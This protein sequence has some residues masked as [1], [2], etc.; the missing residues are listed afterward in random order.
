MS[1]P[2]IGASLALVVSLVAAVPTLQSQSA[3]AGPVEEAG[4]Q[5]VYVISFDENQVTG[6]E[7]QR[8]VERSGGSL[9]DTLEPVGLALVTA[10]GEGFI[11]EVQGIDGVY[12]T[13]R[14]HAVGAAEPGLPHRFA[15][16]EVPPHERALAAIRAVSPDE[17]GGARDD[18]TVGAEPL[19][20]RQWGM[21]MIGATVRDAHR[22]AT[23]QGVDV[24][25]IDTGIDGSHPDLAPNFDANRSRN[26]VRDDA[27][28]SDADANG[29]G[30]HVAGVVAAAD[31]GLGIAGVAP[32]ATLVNLRAGN[33]AGYFFV[34][35]VVSA[36][37]AAG[38]M[39]LDVVN[40]SFFTDPWLY[41]CESADDYLEGSAS[42]EEI[43]EQALVRQEVLEAV[44]YARERGVTLVAAI[45][46][47]H[48]D[49]AAPRRVDEGSPDWPPGAAHR[50][51]VTRNCL[52][53]P[54][55]APGVLSVSSVG[56]SGDKADY[57]NYGLGA[58]DV[59]GP[60]GWFRDRAGTPRFQ[61]PENMV[62]SSYPLEAARGQGLADGSGRP[63]DAF[64][65]QSC[66]AGSCGFYTY[67]QGTSMAAP[68]VTGV[69]ALVVEAR[70]QGTA[71][72]GY[73]LGPE[74]VAEILRATAS[75]QR[76]PASGVLSYH[77]AGRPASWDA[78]CAGDR[79]YNGLYGHG[80]VNA[81][82]A[83]AG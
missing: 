14:N 69:A 64:S 27:D 1:C 2:R 50:R 49:R 36:L 28:P 62:L 38:D 16:E 83:V 73:A 76:C 55:E 37:V 68:F 13:A 22:T 42:R 51:V 5:T 44:A 77:P 57:S 40:M 34:Y 75:E 47:E 66:R 63:T 65:A 11:D 78:T 19:S 18:R 71:T 32:D 17:L 41:N 74:R 39:G 60:G 58:V 7:L 10:P 6:P 30:T 33:D 43:E 45:G 72:S 59:A 24:G 56:P 12:G 20:A 70:G 35:E 82:A 29:H 25:I 79:S 53:L 31:N 4:A 80:L 3:S 15:G 67:L 54:A 21:R 8:S 9:V 61:S 81:A 26:F 48:T 23:G 52:D 46:N